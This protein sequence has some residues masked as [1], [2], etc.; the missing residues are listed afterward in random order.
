MEVGLSVNQK[1]I[2]YTSHV[3]NDPLIWN[4]ILVKKLT[5]DLD[6][7][8]M[9]KAVGNLI[10]RH[11]LLNMNIKLT[12]DKEPVFKGMETSKG[13]FAT[14][15]LSHEKKSNEKHMIE[16]ILKN[17]LSLPIDLH[18]D[19]LFSV[20][21]IKTSDAEYFLYFKIHHII[22]DF[23][24][25]KIIWEDLALLYNNAACEPIDAE[26]SKY[27]RII[28]E[29]MEKK[30]NE[31]EK[32]WLSMYGT[33]INFL[34]FRHEVNA[35]I[36]ASDVIEKTILPPQYIASIEKISLI[37][38]KTSFAFYFSLFL[39]LLY[40][41]SSQRDIVVGTLFSGRQYDPE[42]RK[43]VGFFINTLCLRFN[44]DNTKDFY[45]LFSEVQNIIRQAYNHQDYPL[46]TL[47][48]GI[49][50]DR[51][52]KNGLPY[53]VLFNMIDFR[54]HE[55]HFEGIDKVQ[56]ID[57]DFEHTEVDLSF[58]VRYYDEKLVFTINYDSSVFSPNTAKSLLG[59]YVNLLHQVIDTM[60]Q[61]LDTYALINKVEESAAIK[62]STGDE[63]QMTPYALSHHLI[64]KYRN[65]ERIALMCESK[66]V[67]YSELILKSDIVRNY[68]INSACKVGDSI[69]VY[70]PRTIELVEC[71]IGILKAGCV[72]VPLAVDNP[73]NRNKHIIED[74]NI[75]HVL[76]SREYMGRL[77]VIDVS[78]DVVE[79]I[80][81]SDI[82]ALEGGA[83]VGPNDIAYILFTSGST[84]YPKGVPITHGSLINC[85][86]GYEKIYGPLHE[87]VGLFTTPIMFDI[88]ILEIFSILC[89]GGTLHILSNEIVM[90][91]HKLVQYHNRHKVTFAYLYPGI[92]EAL[93]HELAKRSIIL[94]LQRV[95]IGVEPVSCIMVKKLIEH[96]PKALVVNGY[97]TTETTISST[98]YICRDLEESSYRVPIGKAMPGVQVYVVDKGMNLLPPGIPGEILIGGAGV[99]E[100]YLRSPELSASKFIK[101]PFDES[102]TGKAFLTGDF[103]EYLSDGNIKYLFRKDNQIK[104]AG[105][106]IELEEIENA[107]RSIKKIKNVKVLFEENEIG[108]K[109]INMYYIAED[110]RINIADIKDGLLKRLPSYMHPVNYFKID[111]IPYKTSGKL[112]N[113]ELH[114]EAF[115]S[116]KEN[117]ETI[118]EEAEKDGILDDLVSIIKKI[119]GIESI[120]SN[121]SFFDNGGTSFMVIQLMLEI[122]DKFGIELQIADFLTLPSIVSLAKTISNR[123]KVASK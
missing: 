48:N 111:R 77:S 56:T 40:K 38:R 62:E 31:N 89:F 44:V 115:Q 109:V 11:T 28:H 24:T 23:I 41:Y 114:K 102:G 52:Y 117:I 83:V 21:V 4:K 22:A 112:D 73:I 75:V 6:I 63:M 107:A 58:N 101:N 51:T 25:V 82:C 34:R 2:Y 66:A 86:Q 106:R 37:N 5:G 74:A 33:P 99:A 65:D 100:G 87:R 92:L 78:I 26:Y 67:T 122:E 85:L 14:Q 8:K 53:N 72:Y 61:P 47:V 9:E 30:R 57:I 103:A 50:Y 93:I 29:A 123:M 13:L 54:I 70:L 18:K 95:K 7:N 120:N 90:D 96:A 121:E 12:D 91:V 80:C 81:E 19:R 55:H 43:L 104:F 35:P 69:G 1:R 108:K 113:E 60:K 98:Y 27:N 20:S 10:T 49:T 36:I 119:L 84:G 118:E 59:C 39:L 68:L 45:N 105:Y 97:G 32:Y 71:I 110:S 76:T 64:E 88:S 94:D 116:Y 15:D 17:D 42:L 3:V 16:N 79:D 46:S